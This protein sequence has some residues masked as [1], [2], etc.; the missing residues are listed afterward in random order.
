MLFVIDLLC[1]DN[2][3]ES[4]A[5]FFFFFLN[6]KG[7]INISERKLKPRIRERTYL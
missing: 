2:G 6:E 7:S 5:F 1:K 3:I 4:T